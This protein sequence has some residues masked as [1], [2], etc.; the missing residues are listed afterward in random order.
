MV[1]GSAKLEKAYVLHNL[2]KWDIPTHQHAMQ[3]TTPVTIKLKSW[4]FYHLFILLIT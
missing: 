2:A 3:T 4:E 1:F